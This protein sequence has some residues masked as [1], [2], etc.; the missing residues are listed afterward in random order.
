MASARGLSRADVGWLTGAYLTSRSPASQ[1]LTAG[2]SPFSFLGGP[3][4]PKGTRSHTRAQNLTV[5]LPTPIPYFSVTWT[6]TASGDTNTVIGGSST[7]ESRRIVMAGSA[8]VRKLDDDSDPDG[9]EDAFPFNVTITDDFDKVEIY[10]EIQNGCPQGGPHRDHRNWSITDPNR[11]DPGPDL[12]LR[13]DPAQRADGTWYIQD[14][15]P[16]FYLFRNRRYK[17][18]HDV[19]DCE[20]R[21]TLDNTSYDSGAFGIVAYPAFPAVI[22]GVRRE[23]CSAPADSSRWYARDA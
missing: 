13:I 2:Q 11:D 10:T 22:E 20:G 7:V 17:E 18:T 1:S 23:G 4:T 15:F 8:I 12:W 16:L 5:A 21:T 19:T 6:A 3:A 14:P 9:E